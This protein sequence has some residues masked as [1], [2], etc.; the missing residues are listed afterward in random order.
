MYSMVTILTNI[1]LYTWNF[2]KVG[3]K[4]SYH[5]PKRKGKYE[6]MDVLISFI[7]VIISQFICVPNYH[8]VYLK[9]VQFLP[10]SYTQ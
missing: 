9:Y 5:T 1:G 7:V 6:V 2:L 3:L 4:G 10:V 8:S